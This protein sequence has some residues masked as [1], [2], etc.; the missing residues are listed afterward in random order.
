MAIE[1][2]LNY[3]MADKKIKGKTLAKAIGIT[4]VNLSRI[5]KNKVTSIRFS[6]L[7]ALCEALGCT[8]SDLLVHVEDE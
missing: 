2:R 7:N 8:P 4:E 1:M 5:R 3:V 6:T